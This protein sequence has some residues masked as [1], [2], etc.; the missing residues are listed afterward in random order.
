MYLA[1]WLAAAFL[2]F[3]STCHFASIA[4]TAIRC[5]K[6]ARTPPPAQHPPVTVVRPVC[7][8]DNFVEETLRSSFELDYPDY[9][10]IF[11]VASE[12]DPVVPIVRRLIAAHPRRRARLLVGDERVSTNPKL[13]NCVKGWNAAA[14]DWIVLADSNLLMTPDYLQRLLSRW[15]AETG[16]VCA[17]PVGS[18]PDNFWAELECAFLNTYQLRWQY[19]GDALGRGFAQGKTMLWRRDLLERAGGIA[20]LGAEVAEDAASTKVVRAA[21][22]NVR[23]VD[24][25]FEQPLGR[26]GA[27]EVWQRQMRWARLRRACFPGYFLPEILGGFLPPAIA[28]AVVAAAAGAPIGSSLLALAIAWYGGEMLLAWAAGWYMSARYPLQGLVRD[29]LLP[30]LWLAGLMGSEF[31]WRGNQMTTA[32][33]DEPLPRQA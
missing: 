28:A 4:V 18:H 15:D 29:L 17:P 19:L 24:R 7:G 25:A 8:L 3:A 21:G 5:R 9:E 13:N 22:L 11:C 26:R 23:L 14:H 12:R 20:A 32:E 16:L 2:I 33:D 1:A 6:S 27:I 31:V 10:I 30:A